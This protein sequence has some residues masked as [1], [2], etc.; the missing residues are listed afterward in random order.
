MQNIRETLL[1]S[2]AQL[3]FPSFI[4]YL[5]TEINLGRQSPDPPGSFLLKNS[6][7]VI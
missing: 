1:V 7:Q 5:C 6:S 4:F 2:D 3:T